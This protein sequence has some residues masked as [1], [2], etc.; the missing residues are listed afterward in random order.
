MLEIAD[1]LRRVL[2]PFL[3]ISGSLLGVLLAYLV[4]QRVVRDLA[5]RRRRTLIARYRPLVDAVMKLGSS[6]QALERLRRTP[7]CHRQIVG[8]LLLAPLQAAHGDLALRVRDAAAA[9]GLVDDWLADLQ[10]RRWWLRAAGV[11]ALGFVEE[12]SALPSIMRA[13]DDGHGEVRA[14]AVEAAGRL[15]DPRA[16]PALL[17]QLADGSRHQRVRVVD[18]LRNLGPAVTPAVIELAR[19][20]PDRLKAAIDIL[21]LIGTAAAVDPLLHWCGSPRSDVRAAALDALGSIGLDD[22]GYYFA[23]RALS[24]LDPLVRAMAARALGRGRREAAVDYLAERLDDEWLPAAQ[25]A[26]A[27]RRLGGA[28]LAALQARAG[29]E[30]QAG[31]LARQMLWSWPPI[32]ARA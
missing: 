20:H 13:L 12:R 32:A 22:R 23:L 24:D 19:A 26:G 15:G 14:A 5:S 30:G 7:A 6:Q 18:A 29:N 28:G 11:R 25:A 3:L 31:D 1:L 8:G 16:I 4:L 9:I 21:G 27:L 17:E 10:H 2:V